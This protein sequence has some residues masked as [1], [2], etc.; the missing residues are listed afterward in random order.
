M[1]RSGSCHSWRWGLGCPEL[2]LAHLWEELDPEVAEG[3]KMSQSMENLLVVRTGAQGSESSTG[4]QVS[5][6][7]SGGPGV[8]VFAHNG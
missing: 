5:R 8:G 1:G 4:S 2:V 6:S 7:W 3:P